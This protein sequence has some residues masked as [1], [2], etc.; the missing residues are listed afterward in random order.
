MSEPQATSLKKILGS[1]VSRKELL[2]RYLDKFE[3]W[4][5]NADF[6]NVVAEWKKISVTLNRCVKIVTKQEVTEGLAVDVDKNGPTVIA[7]LQEKC[8]VIQEHKVF[9]G[10]G[11]THARG[12]NQFLEFT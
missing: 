11:D 10:I 8:I 7:E 6:E 4:M 12:F 2:S 5:K 3:A 9:I 1:D